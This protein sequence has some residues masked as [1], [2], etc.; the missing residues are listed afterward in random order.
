M[1]KKII[2]LA[3]LGAAGG[4]GLGVLLSPERKGQAA[5][6]LFPPE[7]LHGYAEGTTLKLREAGKGGGPVVYQA[8]TPFGLRPDQVGPTGLGALKTLRQQYPEAKRLAVFLAEDSAMADASNWVAL[9]EYVDGT[10]KLTGGHPTAAQLDSIAAAGTPLRRPTAGDLRIAAKVFDSTGG[11]RTE[12]WR[13]ARSLVGASGHVDKAAFAKLDLETPVL[14][15]TAK[16]VG[17][18]QK[19]VQATVL[20]VTRYYWLRAGDPL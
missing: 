2:L 14:H 17:K 13:L 16:A 15:K 19:E 12:R 20:A 9:A 4:V 18:T 11:L 1:N 5:K 7:K 8:V 6:D 10:L 3:L